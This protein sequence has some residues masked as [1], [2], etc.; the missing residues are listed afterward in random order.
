MFWKKRICRLTV[1]PLTYD[2]IA[3]MISPDERAEID[4]QYITLVCGE[5]PLV[6]IDP[7]AAHNARKLSGHPC[8]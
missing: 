1:S 4:M 3:S 6:E 5:A 8:G 2:E 7:I